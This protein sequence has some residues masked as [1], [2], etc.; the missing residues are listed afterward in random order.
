MRT[1]TPSDLVH[2]LWAAVSLLLAAGLFLVLAPDLAVG[3]EP[4]SEP[5][6]APIEASGPE[7]DATPP[8]AESTSS[9]SAPSEPPAA[10]PAGEATD[11][12]DISVDELLNVQTSVATRGVARAQRDTPAIVTVVTR[13]EIQKS[14]ARDMLDV[15]NYVAGFA[16]GVDI[17]SGVTAGF[18]GMWGA[19]GKILT[20]IDGHEVHELSYLTTFFG[21]HFSVDWIDRVEIIRGP[22]SVIYGGAAE[23]AV[24]SII[25]RSAEALSGVSATAVYGQMLDGAL[26][27][28]RGFTNTFAQRNVSLSYGQVLHD[29]NDLKVKIDL[30]AGQGNRSDRDYV[31]FD[32][33]SY[34]LASRYGFSNGKIVRAGAID[35]MAVNAALEF[36]GLSLRYLFDDFRVTSQD[37]SGGELLPYPIPVSYKTHSVLAEYE[38]HALDNLK[39]T[40][41]FMYIWQNPWRTMSAEA[42]VLDEEAWNPKLQR[43]QPGLRIS[44]EPIAELE[45]LAGLDYTYDRSD[46]QIYGY[47]APTIADL[48]ATTPVVSYTNVAAYVQGLLDTSYA[49]VSAGAR[50]EHHSQVGNSFVPRAAITRSFGPAHGKLLYSQAMRVPN[51][52]NLGMAPDLTGITVVDPCDWRM[53]LSPERTTVVE[54]ELGYRITDYLAATVNGY[55]VSIRRAIIYGMDPK[56]NDTRYRNFGR[57]G[58]RGIEA[59]LRY[60]QKRVW[61]TLGYSY[62]NASG[63]NRNV[64]AY[65]IPGHDDVLAGFAPHKVSFMGGIDLTE[66]LSA[67]VTA[68]YFGSRHAF[69]GFESEGETQKQKVKRFPA[70]TLLNLYL[71]HRNVVTPGL[72]ASL[73]LY[74]L[75][76]TDIYYVQPYNGEHG[77][78]PGPSFEVLVKLGYDYSLGA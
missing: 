42:R 38:L 26:N 23:L 67:N 47:P 63:K 69:F 6:P 73:G 7:T 20:L 48:E 77:A 24:I 16:F 76:N 1:R 55:D 51:I 68:L 5:T 62:Y 8:A 21:N 31:N 57:T 59:E 11:I 29:R 37:G 27:N 2:E 32:G 34:N 35:P 56:C 65:A 13:E 41:R 72:S 58:T 33:E 52:E 45:I 36:H 70:E 54:L 50:F 3:Q 25:T 78:I 71:L 44:Y 15:L 14:G 60:K 40:P 9:D 4:P 61:A 64:E 10:T 43:V 19:E 75:L 22:G 46:D 74:N 18:R 17:L 28:G 39:V 49:D 12:A 30:F 66:D 53:P